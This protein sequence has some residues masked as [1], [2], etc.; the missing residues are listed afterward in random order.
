MQEWNEGGHGIRKT[1][2]RYLS[3]VGDKISSG[4]SDEN[5]ESEQGSQT[6]LSLSIQGEKIVFDPGIKGTN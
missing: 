4:P 2:Q 3:S 1:Y 6:V 5:P